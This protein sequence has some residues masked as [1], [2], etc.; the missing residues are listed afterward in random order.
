M[1]STEACWENEEKMGRGKQENWSILGNLVWEL[2]IDSG[3]N[4]KWSP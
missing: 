1:W 4:L 2:D 3:K